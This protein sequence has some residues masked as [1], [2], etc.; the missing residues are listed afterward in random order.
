M[1]FSSSVFI[2]VRF[3]THCN[4]NLKLFPS[5][6][7]FVCSSSLWGNLLQRSKSQYLMRNRNFKVSPPVFSVIHFLFRYHDLTSFKSLFSI[8][9]SLTSRLPHLHPSSC[10]MSG[11]FFPGQPVE[12]VWPY[13][14][15]EKKKEVRFGLA[16]H[17]LGSGRGLETNC[18]SHSNFPLL[19]RIFHSGALDLLFSKNHTL[20]DFF[21]DFV[22]FSAVVVLP[23]TILTFK[24]SIFSIHQ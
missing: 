24:F 11:S 2:P 16:R 17:V 5:K 9:C 8:R 22:L 20:F 18:S 10:F 19:T 7:S 21:L 4:L 12:Q 1:F 15:H 3:V 23:F 6:W 13:L 14:Q